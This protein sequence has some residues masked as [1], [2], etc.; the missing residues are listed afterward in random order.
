VRRFPKGS[1][2]RLVVE[3]AIATRTAP[4]DW[5]DEDDNTI[6]TALDVLEIQ[7]KEMRRAH[8]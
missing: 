6:A 1:R 5:W 3:L 8:R 4:R 7:A 2:A